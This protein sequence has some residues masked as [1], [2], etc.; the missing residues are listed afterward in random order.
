[1]NIVT[2]TFVLFCI[3]L[4][5]TVAAE[6]ENENEQC[7]RF[8]AKAKCLSLSCGKSKSCSQAC[9][10]HTCNDM[11][12]SSG[13]CNQVCF[14]CA[15]TKMVCSAPNCSQTCSGDCEMEC[16]AEVKECSQLCEANSTCKMT[17]RDSDTTRCGQEC[18]DGS[19]CTILPGRPEV[20]SSCDESGNCSAS[21]TGNC[22]GKT[23][24]CDNKV[25]DLK[26]EKGC[27]MKC[28]KT[29]EKCEMTCV[30]NTPCSRECKA[31][32]CSFTGKFHPTSS[33]MVFR[34]NYLTFVLFT[35]MMIFWL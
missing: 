2:S 21:C 34:L 24:T 35:F 19:T 1:M 22:E 25:C 9:F 16:T 3:A 28:G 10:K 29:V 31:K 17:C 8:C 32:I 11:T 12:C 14:N 7:V 4:V 5:G 26:C 15:S 30:G 23:I 27:S 33:A 18:V 20:E 6:C 13:S